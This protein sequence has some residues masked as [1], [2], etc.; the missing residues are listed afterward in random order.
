MILDLVNLT[1][2]TSHD[3]LGQC[4][5]AVTRHYGHGSSYKIKHLIE[6]CLQFQRFSPLSSWQGMW[7]HSG[8]FGS[9]G[10]YIWIPREQEERLRVLHL[11]LKAAGERD[12]GFGFGF[13][14][15]KAHPSDILSKATPTN[16]ATPPNS[17]K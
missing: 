4:S 10:F 7:W 17:F 14:N 9:C 16:K 13:W 3:C 1:V 15:L 5:V 12:T 6:T 2:L 11:D 8:R